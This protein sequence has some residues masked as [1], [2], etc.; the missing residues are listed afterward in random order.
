MHRCLRTA[1][2]EKLA[3]SVSK[4]EYSPMR[5]GLGI[6]R[7]NRLGAPCNCR[8]FCSFC[9]VDPQIAAQ[10]VATYGPGQYFGERALM[11]ENTPRAA[12]AVTKNA[13]MFYTLER[14]AFQNLL[15][16]LDQARSPSPHA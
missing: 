1:A 3:S 16:P 12:T 14:T 11:K 2:V 7:G 6:P 13:C 8:P 10:V 15:G 9:S 5:P 4:T